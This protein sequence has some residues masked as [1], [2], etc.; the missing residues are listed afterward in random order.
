VNEGIYVLSECLF[1][2]CVNVFIVN[3]RMSCSV[4]EWRFVY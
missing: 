2:E 1:S 4:N 3:E